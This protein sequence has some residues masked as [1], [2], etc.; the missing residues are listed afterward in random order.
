MTDEFIEFDHPFENMNLDDSCCFLCGIN[1]GNNSTKEDLIPMWLQRKH[2]LFKKKLTLLN[3]TQIPYTQL[4]IPCCPKCNNEHLSQ[5]ESKISIAI[6][7]GY[8]TSIELEPTLFFYWAAKIFY[9]ILRKE[10]NLLVDRSNPQ[11]GSIVPETLIQAY[12]NLHTFMQGIRR[13]L[14]FIGQIPFSVLVANLHEIGDEKSFDFKDNI[15]CQTLS[16]RSGGVGIIVALADAGVNNMSY[17][18]YLKAVDGRKLHPI[19]FDELFAKVTYESFRLSNAPFFT[20]AS[21]KNNKLPIQVITHT[22]GISMKEWNQEEFAHLLEN[23]LAD[24]GI[25]EEGLF[26]PPNFVRTSMSTENGSLMLMDQDGNL[27]E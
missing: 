1:M 13:P 11:K 10:L 20:V 9:G 21:N 5:L 6:N 3:G 14:E 24:W 27:I 19:Q 17:S 25:P 4:K 16:I 23:I 7:S 12:K 26:V 22:N 15:I 18:R 8:S 2:N